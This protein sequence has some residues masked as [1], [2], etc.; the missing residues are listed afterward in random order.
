[1]QTCFVFS[2]FYSIEGC[3]AVVWLLFG[4]CLKKLF[5]VFFFHSEYYTFFFNILLYIKIFFFYHQKYFDFLDRAPKKTRDRKL[6][7]F[8]DDSDCDSS[9]HGSNTRDTASYCGYGYEGSSPGPSNRDTTA[10]QHDMQYCQAEG[11]VD[12]RATAC[13]ACK[14]VLCIRHTLTGCDKHKKYTSVVSDYHT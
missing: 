14:Q 10:R 9:I 5:V 8:F 2:V 7:N 4:C 12:P 13:P 1:M 6:F 11:C 3:S